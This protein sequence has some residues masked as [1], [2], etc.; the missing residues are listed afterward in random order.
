MAESAVAKG[1]KEKTADFWQARQM[2][3]EAARLQIIKSKTF[4]VETIK[5]K[6][7][8]MENTE[9]SAKAVSAKAESAKTES[10]KAESAKAE[11]VKEGSAKKDEPVNGKNLE[12]CTNCEE[13][14]SVATFSCKECEDYLCEFCYKAHLRV[15]LT[16]NHT[17]K[18]I[19]KICSNCEEN[20]I[21][22]F[23]CKECGDYL[24]ESCHQAHLRVKLTRNHTFN[25]ILMTFP[26]HRLK[27]NKWN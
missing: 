10:A 26:L 7:I 4:K 15:K 22:S 25:Y 24:C 13:G 23:S 27:P 14:N 11:T 18:V 17:I 20:S 21:A 9:E 1:A 5:E 6:S 12:L 19:N 2:A 16:R 3:W 8:K